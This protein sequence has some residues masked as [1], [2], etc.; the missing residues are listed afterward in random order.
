[1]LL[2]TSK[3]RWLNMMR[4]KCVLMF[5]LVLITSQVKANLHDSHYAIERHINHL[6]WFKYAK[7][8]D[9]SPQVL[10]AV[11]LKESGKLI[12]ERFLP[13]PFAIGVGVQKSIGQMEHISI[14]PETKEEAQAVLNQLIATGH[15]N[16]GIGLMQI[17]WLYHH[18]KVNTVFDLLN[19]ETNLRVAAKILKA[20]KKR[21]ITDFNAL[22]CYSY[23]EGDD[24]DGLIY[25]NKAFEYANTYGSSFVGR[26]IPKG[27]P[28]GEL[29]ET[30]LASIW[31]NIDAKSQSVVNK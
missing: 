28:V 16:L 29:N 31:K 3:K 21:N 19:T 5:M 2:G 7:V 27:P 6:D 20:C 4:Y 9:V 18:D 22:S 12:N 15:T 1:M 25:A 10:Y 11:A 24:P 23:G 13:S 30:Y 17:S 26:L 14:Y 8:A